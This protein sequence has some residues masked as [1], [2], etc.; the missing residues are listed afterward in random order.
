[1]TIKALVFAM[2]MLIFGG[3]AAGTVGQDLTWN[4]AV[5][6]TGRADRAVAARIETHTE[7][8]DGHGRRLET[9]DEIETLTGWNGPQPI[10]TSD[11]TR[12]VD[13]KSGLEVAIE[14]GTRDNPF[15]ASTE[16]RVTYQRVGEDT[17]D[18]RACI[19]FRFEERPAPAVPALDTDSSPAGKRAAEGKG[20][21]VGPLLGTAW[22]E[23]DTGFPLKCVYR[24]KKMPRHVSVYELTVQFSTLPN[25]SAV[26]RSLD[27]EMRAGF[28]WYKRVVRLHKSLSEWTTSPNTAADQPPPGAEPADTR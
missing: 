8:Y 2:C 24:P 11:V 17:L 22:V 19:A 21:E 1:M 10:R 3:G 25:G 28:L 5:A 13:R 7:V 6:T 23:R 20:D 15:V 18:G 12:E 4:R 16:G 9:K 14:V 27:L 26:P